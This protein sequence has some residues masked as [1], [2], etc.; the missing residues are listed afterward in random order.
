MI[1]FGHCDFVGVSFRMSQMSSDK[2]E[3]KFVPFRCLL[4]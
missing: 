1:K 2:A 4:N 3:P